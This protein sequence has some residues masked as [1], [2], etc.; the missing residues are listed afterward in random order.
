MNKATP[1]IALSIDDSWTVKSSK[2]KKKN[3]NK[4]L[5]LQKEIKEAKQRDNSLAIL[6]KHITN[7]AY[8]SDALDSRE[9]YPMKLLMHLN[10]LIYKWNPII[11]KTNRKTGEEFSIGRGE[12]WISLTKFLHKRIDR[13][14]FEQH[15]IKFEEILF[16][17]DF[18]GYFQNVLKIGFQN[19]KNL[20]PKITRRWKN[21][22]L[23]KQTTLS[24]FLLENS[25]TTYLKN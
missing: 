17:S 2:N 13:E 18:I 14:L 16:S 6:G 4:K 15:G 11:T 1:T 20:R 8:G 24:K 21:V 9:S 23:I 7:A 19:T 5:N 10:Y 12:V 25:Q 22:V 3:Q